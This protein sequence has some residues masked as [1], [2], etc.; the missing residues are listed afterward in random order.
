MADPR[1]DGVE[2]IWFDDYDAARRAIASIEYQR[3]FF[4]D[5][6]N[7]SESS[8][9]FFAETAMLMWPGKALDAV[10]REIATRSEQ[11]WRD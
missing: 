9:H 5:F 2:E 1:W 7:F 4:P 10:R 6:E 3:S 11:P 8:A